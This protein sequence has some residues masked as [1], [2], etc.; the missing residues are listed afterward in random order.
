MLALVGDNKMAELVKKADKIYQKNRKLIEK[1]QESDLFGSDLYDRLDKLSLLDDEYY[2]MNKKTM[3]YIVAYIRNH[4]N[5]ICLDEDGNEL[6]RN[7]TGLCQT[8][9]DDQTIKEA[10][11]LEKGIINGPFSAFYE[12]G[13]TKE[14]IDYQKGAPTGEKK[15]FYDDGKLKHQVEKFPSKGIFMHQWFYSNG[16]PKKSESKLIENE[17]RIGVYQEWFENGQ[18]SKKGTYKSDYEREGEWLE[19]YENGS[20]KLEAQFI[21]S[22]LRP[23]NHWNEQGEQTLV[24]GTGYRE[25]FSKPHFKGDAP[26]FYYREYKDAAAH[27]VWKEFKNDIL[28]SLVHYQDGKRHGTMETYY[29]NG[30]LQKRKIFENGKLTSETKFPKFKD[31]KVK[32]AIVSVLCKG[33]YEDNEAYQLPDNE[34]GPINHQELAADFKAEVSLF[35]AYGDD[36][37][38]S[39]GYN[40]FV[41]EK[42]DVDKVT[43]AVADN[44]WLDEQVKASISKLRFEPALKD[45]QPIKS[46]HYTRYRLKLV[47]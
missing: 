2:E 32:T 43:F 6:D 23:K 1:A 41:N 37:T 9:Y 10:L 35:E 4:P 45:G 11:Q 34:P 44:M 5:E 14:I 26:P 16:N 17:E 27:G 46:I 3:S 24:N 15:T 20:P 36:K 8:F 33:C 30:N 28:Q 31:P 40:V 29:E 13:E 21:N 47:E 12:N 39:Y 18:L 7:F 42:G 25:Y 19:Y 22:V 38:I